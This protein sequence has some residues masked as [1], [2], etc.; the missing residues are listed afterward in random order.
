MTEKGSIFMNSSSAARTTKAGVT[1][2]SITHTLT[3][4]IYSCTISPSMC[5][6]VPSHCVAPSFI[7][8]H[9]YNLPTSECVAKAWL[10]GD[11]QRR[12]FNICISYVTARR[13]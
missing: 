10:M 13:R 5:Y 3:P 9:F 8:F 11:L 12:D 7:H 6:S 4:Q 1:M 2:N